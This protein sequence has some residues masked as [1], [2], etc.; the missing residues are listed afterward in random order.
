MAI[1][2]RKR[3]AYVLHGGVDTCSMRSTPIAI[4]SGG[5]DLRQ[6]KLNELL[7]VVS[8]T[9]RSAVVG[10]RQHEAGNAE[11]LAGAAEPA[12][13]YRHDSRKGPGFATFS[14]ESIGHRCALYSAGI[15]RMKNQA[16]QYFMHD[17]PSAFRFEL[18]GDLNNEGARRLQQDWRTAS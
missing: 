3:L 5:L 7:G 14:C 1:E 15:K 17:G 16:L 9:R 18:A 11:A 2:D 6:I 4:C 10:N 8:Y 13:L 12:S